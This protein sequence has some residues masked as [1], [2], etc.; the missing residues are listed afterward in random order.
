MKTMPANNPK[1][2][3]LVEDHAILAMGQQIELESYGYTVITANTGEKAIKIFR[4]DPEI[5]LILMDINLGNGIS[6]TE[7]AI[8]ILKARRVPV[9]FLSSHTVQEAIALTRG[10]SL[11]GYVVKGSKVSV[12]D[13]S[14]KRECSLFNANFRSMSEMEH[15]AIALNSSSAGSATRNKYSNHFHVGRPPIPKGRP[16]F[17]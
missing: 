8:Q 10:L 11:Y 17:H 5:D 7:T 13:E 12:V 15:L 4:A 14:I 6:G 3:L 1:T 2:I 16:F 9:I